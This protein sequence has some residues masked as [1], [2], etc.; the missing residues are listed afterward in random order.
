M[1]LMCMGFFLIFDHSNLRGAY[2]SQFLHVL[3]NLK[4]GVCVI[5]LFILFLIPTNKGNELN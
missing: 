5:I 4:L 3:K 1:V 2:F